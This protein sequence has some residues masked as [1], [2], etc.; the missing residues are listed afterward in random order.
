MLSMLSNFRAPWWG[1]VVISLGV[2]LIE[3]T[4][5]PVPATT[6]SEGTA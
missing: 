3:S 2:S 6:S 5:V 1:L 4:A